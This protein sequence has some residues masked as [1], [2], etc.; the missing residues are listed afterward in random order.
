MDTPQLDDLIDAVKNRHADGHALDFLTD[1]VVVAEHLGEMADHLVGHF[2]ALARMQGASW[3]EIGQSLGVTKQAA[4]KRFVPKTP[5]ETAEADLRTFAR[6][7][8]EARTVVVQAQEEARRARHDHIGAEHIVL[9][10]L[11]LPEAPSGRALTALGVSPD[12]LRESIAGLIGPPGETAPATHI[13]FSE[14]G[15]KVLE[16]THGEAQRLGHDHI[17]AEHVLLGVLSLGEGPAAEF[18]RLG[19]TKERVESQLAGP[20]GDA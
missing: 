15:R 11:R 6:Y 5:T 19:V 9:A 10:L 13:A 3:A 4:Q 18:A 7:T 8:A 20:P 16:L 12:A 1:A 2:V 14:Q 17:G